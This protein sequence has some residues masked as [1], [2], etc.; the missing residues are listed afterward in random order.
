MQQTLTPARPAPKRLPRTSAVEPVVSVRTKDLCLLTRQLATL[1]HAGMPLVPALSALAEQFQCAGAGRRTRALARL[2]A[3]IRDKVNAGASLSSALAEHP[4]VFGTFFVPMVAAGE[5]G[6]TLED[7]FSRLADTL[8]RRNRLKVQVMASLAY[9][10]LMVVVATAVVLFLLTYVVPGLIQVF[11]DMDRTMPWPTRALIWISQFIRHGWLVLGIGL[12]GA[13]LGLCLAFRSEPGKAIWD[14]VRAALPW[15]GPLLLKVEVARMART[16]GTLLG[17]GVPLLR[18]LAI[19]GQV[20][21]HGRMERAW[22]QVTDSVRTGDTLAH[23]LRRTAVFP[24]LVCHLVA[25]GESTGTVEHGLIQ[26]ADMAE[27]EVQ[28]AV[29]ALA[30]L[31]EPLVLLAM[32]LVVG[33]IVMAVLLPIFDLNQALGS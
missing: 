33:F 19:T 9:P 26:I 17:A 5:V 11:Q 6:G 8:E 1:L 7:V 23:A 32:G 10:T 21:R 16:L 31:V 3:R 18:A 27:Q 29:K 4:E 12:C 30:S 28:A 15:V 20:L 13:L 14:R 24:P 2:V 22:A 25:T